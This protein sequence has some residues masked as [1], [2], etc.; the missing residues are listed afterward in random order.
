MKYKRVFKNTL[1]ITLFIVLTAITQIGGI[2]YLISEIVVKRSTTK[3]YLKKIGVFLSIYLLSTYA[4]TPIIAPVFGRE[5]I[6][7]S[8]N[9]KAH[10]F[11]T[12]LL[13]RNYV[14]HKMQTAIREIALTFDKKH[15]Q[16]K[17]IYLDAN[18]PFING[19]PL[20]PHL[21]HNDGNKIDISFIYQNKEGQLTNKKPS[22]SG[23]G[24]FES[25]A[26]NEYDQIKFCTQKGYWQYEITK[27][28]T[29]GTTNNDLKLSE[30]ATKDLLLTILKQK[31]IGKVFIEPHLKTRLKLQHSKI[32]YHG[33]QAVRHDDHIHI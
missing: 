28:I 15:P 6:V 32:R 20:L 10:T 25:P 31:Q 21:S 9:I 24:I 12:N 3:Y 23:Y 17:L 1:K 18:F 13:N 30:K 22:V 19:F 27:H 7:E 33:C 29:L 16:I 8:Q 5:R 14:S 4:L 2:V 11:L 26:S